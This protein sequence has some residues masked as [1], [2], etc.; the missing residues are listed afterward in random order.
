MGRQQLRVRS[1]CIGSAAKQLMIQL[2]DRNGDTVSR[3]FS[4]VLRAFTGARRAFFG[5]PSKDGKI[6]DN[7]FYWL[8][9]DVMKFL[10]KNHQTPMPDGWFNRRC[11][12]E[13]PGPEHC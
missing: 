2:L 5:E 1:V 13:W 4:K 10:R 3:V 7:E 8:V 11:F 9:A 6:Y 12:R